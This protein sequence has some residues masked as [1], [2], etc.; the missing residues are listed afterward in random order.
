[1]GDVESL[2]PPAAPVSAEPPGLATEIAALDNARGLLRAGQP[3]QAV[4]AL[5]AYDRAFVAPMLGPE[6]AVLR[7]EALT[8]LGEHAAAARAARSFLRAHSDS[9]LA[10]RV[11]SLVP[12]ASNP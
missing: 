12:E 6:A 10:G 5:D 3:A 2:A 1:V 11:R 9:P 8:K 4:R 7:I